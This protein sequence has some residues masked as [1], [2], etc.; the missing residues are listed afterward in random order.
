MGD[1]VNIKIKQQKEDKKQRYSSIKGIFDCNLKQKSNLSVIIKVDTNGAMEAIKTSLLKISIENIELKII[2]INIGGIN[3][4]DI[5]L[6]IVSK[7]LL[8]GFNVKADI[9]AKK[10]AEAENI[11]IIYYNI[12]YE[13]IDYIKKTMLEKSSPTIKEKITGTA[14][15]RNIFT[16]SKFGIIAGCIVIEGIIK[17]NNFIK[18]LRNKEVIYKGKLNSLKHFKE[19]VL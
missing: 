12:I 5:N 7:S 8:I 4:S 14:K 19:N 10:L 9:T 15:V 2:D 3:S 1:I 13:L 17:K 6:A 16:S 18:I 11:K